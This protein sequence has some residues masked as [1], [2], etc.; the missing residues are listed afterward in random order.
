[1]L[2]YLFRII[3]NKLV[4]TKIVGFLLRY[5]LTDVIKNSNSYLIY[6]ILY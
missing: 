3:K 5:S 4:Y 6:L 1:M 2:V